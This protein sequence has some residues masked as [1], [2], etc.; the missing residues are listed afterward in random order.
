MLFFMKDSRFDI[1]TEKANRVIRLMNLGENKQLDTSELVDVVSKETGTVIEVRETDFC[2]IIENCHYGAMMCVNKS[3]DTQSAFIVLNSN[4]KID[5]KFRKFSLVHE[6]GHL[7][8]GRY[9][10]S[11]DQNNYT[12]STHI[13]YQFN[14]IKEDDY[15]DNTYLLNEEIANIFA[16]RVLLPFDA[17]VKKMNND[18]D[19]KRISE[20]F[21]VSENAV[22]ARLRLGE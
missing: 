1:A 7:M 19:L 9:N 10:I 14:K 4:E 21:G 16:L 20:Y 6:L 13:D 22:L 17:L 5:D 2:K 15:K 12:L 8:T 11:V 18:F 3:N